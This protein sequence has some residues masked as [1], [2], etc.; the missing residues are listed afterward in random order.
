MSSAQVQSARLT[1]FERQC[2]NCFYCGVAMWMT[3]P[4][5]LP[6]CKSESS[7]YARLRC[8]AEHLVARSEGGRDC[9]ANIVAACAHCN[10]TRHKKKRPPKPGRYQAEVTRRVA[11]G[12]W[13]PR[14]V[15]ERG[16][17]S[18]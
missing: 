1:S 2:G 3:T 11:R 15:H 9:S 16:L 4:F 17:L 10:S 13:H 7:G 8:T 12:A 14:W 6:G 18:S 5:E